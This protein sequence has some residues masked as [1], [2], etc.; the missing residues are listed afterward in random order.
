LIESFAGN[1]IAPPA[2]FSLIINGALIVE[3]LKSPF[4]PMAVHAQIDEDITPLGIRPVNQ[5][6][7]QKLPD[8]DLIIHQQRGMK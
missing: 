3:R 7:D 2:L 1:R 6:I 5:S 8:H 4:N